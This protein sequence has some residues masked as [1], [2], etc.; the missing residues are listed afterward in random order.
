MPPPA[1]TW[2]TT[3]PGEALQAADT[4]T[5][6]AQAEE[7]Q[8]TEE[9]QGAEGGEEGKADEVQAEAAAAESETQS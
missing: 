5:E 7:V 1:N 2:L 4:D 6:A 8:G 3:I 9:G